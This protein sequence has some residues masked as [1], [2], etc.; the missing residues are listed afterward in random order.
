VLGQLGQPHPHGS[1]ETGAAG[2]RCH[3]GPGG[4]LGA[5]QVGG[6]V[7]RSGVD[8]KI[9]IGWPRLLSQRGQGLR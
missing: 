5:Q 9:N 1:P 7:G 6:R 2:S 3:R 4:Q 8:A